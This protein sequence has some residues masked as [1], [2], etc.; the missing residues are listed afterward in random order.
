MKCTCKNCGTTKRYTQPFNT[1][2]EWLAPSFS[3]VYAYT[4]KSYPDLFNP[5]ITDAMNK[6]N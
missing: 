5:I 6:P 1:D 4:Y 2:G 3:K